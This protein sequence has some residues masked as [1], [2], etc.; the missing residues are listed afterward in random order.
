MN[1]MMSLMIMMG[2]GLCASN[3]NHDDSYNDERG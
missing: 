3:D 1:N 2:L